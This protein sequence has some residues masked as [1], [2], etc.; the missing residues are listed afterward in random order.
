MGVRRERGHADAVCPSGDGTV[1]SA[2]ILVW[3][4]SLDRFYESAGLLTHYPARRENRNDT[5]VD[6]FEAIM[7]PKAR[8]SK[9]VV[10]RVQV[11]KMAIP[12][13]GRMHI[14]CER[15]PE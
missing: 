13:A 3:Y 7:R 1:V 11:S 14:I 6:D 5:V 9:G 8:L 2:S 15:Y 12:E 10:G 4:V